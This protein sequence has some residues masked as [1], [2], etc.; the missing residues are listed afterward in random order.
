[1]AGRLHVPLVALARI[2]TLLSRT[3]RKTV[4]CPAYL[5][6]ARSLVELGRD[7][8][9]VR[10]FREADRTAPNR[11]LRFV[12]RLQMGEALA[13]LGRGLD[14]LE[15][16]GRL[17]QL[18]RADSELAQ[19]GLAVGL[20]H[21]AM[22]DFAAAEEA[23]RNVVLAYPREDASRHARMELAMML[24]RDRHDFT[25]SLAE[26]EELAK[27]GT[28]RLLVEEAGRRAKALR[29]VERLRAALA[30]S[31]QARPD[32][33]MDLAELYLLRLQLP[34]SALPLL[35][36]VG[37]LYADSA[38]AARALYGAA[39]VSASRGDSATAES[40]WHVLV[41]KHP[42]S[43][44]ARAVRA[45]RGELPVEAGESSAAGWAYHLGELAW[46][47]ARDAPRALAAFSVVVDS[48][49][50]AS[51]APRA[52]LAM[53]WV[54]AEEYHDTLRA[55]EH[56][57]ALADRYA[58]TE[59]GRWAALA[60]G[61]ATVLRH[62]PY[63]V[64]P[65]LARIDTVMCGEIAPV[66][67]LHR[68]GSVMVRVLIDSAGIARDVELVKGTGSL[69]CDDAALGAARAADYVS[70]QRGSAPVEAWLDLSV[71]FLPAGRDTT[72]GPA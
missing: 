26:Y 21:R 1:V 16:F 64:A 32:A 4:T 5:L 34:D 48:F 69:L 52:L 25:G 41:A 37:A 22:G 49:P 6:R 28:P 63:D 70:A 42:D 19:V 24:E 3:D 55:R 51:E 66:D 35:T 62:Q 13:R 43:R 57:R 36:Q 31:G 20:S 33:L 68:L 44:H 11:A 40:L 27:Q 61:T 58:D 14:A 39:W 45:G 30:E 54:E 67:S 65:R 7:E 46:L 10:W 8:E 50:D 23:W 59:P 12:A 53:A 9:A 17:R 29:D 72:D 2:D 60:S 56:L 15:A 18:A 71:P 47:Q 38:W